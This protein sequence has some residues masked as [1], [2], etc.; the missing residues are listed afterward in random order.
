MILISLCFTLFSGYLLSGVF[1]RDLP[2]TERLSLAFPLG[3]ALTSY[4]IWI[5]LFFKIS[6]YPVYFLGFQ[7]FLLFVLYKLTL[8]NDISWSKPKLIFNGSILLISAL[9]L[10]SIIFNLF[11]PVLTPDGIYYKAL[12]QVVLQE[13]NIMAFRDR[14]FVID[15]NRTLGFHMVS[16]YWTLFGSSTHK[17]I[18]TFNYVSLIGLFY[19]LIRRFLDQKNSFII[20]LL[21]ATAPMI[22]WHSFLYLNNLQAGLYFFAANTYWFIAYRNKSKDLLF[23]ASFL[24]MCAQWTRYE[25]I[26]LFCVPLTISIYFSIKENDPKWVWNLLSFP[27]FFSGIWAAYSLIFYPR[28]GHTFKFVFLF[29]FFILFW[30]VPKIAIKFKALIFR[31]W[32]MV[33]VLA[34]IGYFLGI[35]LFF[36]A[37]KATL[38]SE[39]TLAK[40]INN[41]L[42]QSVWGLG[43]L[44]TLVI[45]FYYSNFDH[46]EKAIFF[47]LLGIFVGF[48]LLFSV[49]VN[50][51]PM[52]EHSIW[53]RTLFF[54]QHPGQIAVRT[55]S[56]EFFI[57]FPTLLLFLG[58]IILGKRINKGKSLVITNTLNSNSFRNP[59][60]LFILG[61]LVIIF[62]FFLSP[63]I[64]FMLK[65]WN[66]PSQE[67]LISTG[68][69][70]IHNLY[71]DTYLIARAVAKETPANSVIYFPSPFGAL[72]FKKKPYDSI[73]VFMAM[74][75]LYPRHLFWHGYDQKIPEDL[76]ERPKY[77]VS[78]IGWEYDRCKEN[79]FKKSLE[80][81][82]WQICKLN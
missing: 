82:N 47:N 78:L 80:H 35:F 34:P 39:I 49:F 69:K 54:I 15:Q 58:I 8:K 5:A 56:R 46:L 32:P 65:Q 59:L 48:T 7:T 20:L 29:V 77:Q 11:Y 31:S 41:I 6:L 18:Q 28:Q 33:L 21:L 44:L 73:G 70:D 79:V 61:N 75:E 50:G 43:V 42:C 4:F 1:S 12:G 36:G 10:P 71:I 45:P 19:S 63:R 16:A 62:V 55:S 68:P 37:E 27:L 57:L 23:L 25:L 30:F 81:H 26:V 22:W 13:S 2:T 40:T 51:H 67:I 14:T 38:I 66:R 64:D 17:I 60:R 24:F 53:Q 76:E 74:D 52:M 72:N 9:V 3:I